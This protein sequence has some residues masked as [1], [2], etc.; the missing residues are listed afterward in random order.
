MLNLQPSEQMANDGQHRARRASGDQSQA[1]VRARKNA[2]RAF[3]RAYDG[4]MKKEDEDSSVAHV[5]KQLKQFTFVIFV[6]F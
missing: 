3:D 5:V 6:W 2:F 4:Q 1:G